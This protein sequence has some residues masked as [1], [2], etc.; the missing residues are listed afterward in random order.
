MKTGNDD[1][2][3]LHR[4]GLGW[5]PTRGGPDLLADDR[6][7]FFQRR[8]LSR[9]LEELLQ[10]IVAGERLHKTY[11]QMKMYNDPSLNPYLYQAATRA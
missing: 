5:Q 9:S 10:A 3:S 4:A 2:A 6:E 1:I 11:R 7:A 8:D